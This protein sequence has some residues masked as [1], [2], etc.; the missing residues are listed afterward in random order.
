MGL[1]SKSEEIRC[2]GNKTDREYCWLYY[3]FLTTAMVI[4]LERY[5]YE[6]MKLAA[7][8]AY[9]K[10]MSRHATGG[11]LNNASEFHSKVRTTQDSELPTSLVLGRSIRNW[12]GWL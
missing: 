4:R 8:V 7:V 11:G 12:I 10:V 5:K 6:R 9:V 1:K 3:D 2:T